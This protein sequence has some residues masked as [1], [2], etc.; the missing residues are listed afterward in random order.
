MKTQQPTLAQT[1][2]KRSA[3]AEV[4][5]NLKKNKGA[6][7]GLAIVALLVFVAVF[8]DVIYDYDTDI[9]EQHIENRLQP[10]SLEHICGTDELGRDIFS[11]LVYGTRFSLSV[12]VLAVIIALIFGVT[13]GAVAGYVGGAVENVI[14]RVTDMFSAIPSILMAIAIVAAMGATTFN[15]MLAIGISSTPA[16]VRVSRAAVLTE[17]NQEYVESARA[18]GMPDWKIVLIHVLPNS[19]SP[20]IVQ[21]TLRVASAIVSASGLS[22]LGLGVPAPAPEWGG[23]LS[24]GRTYIRDYSY[25]SLFPGLAIMITVLSLNLLGDGL[26]DAIDPKLKT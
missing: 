20:I 18:V 7:V 2:K 14:M 21:A 4:W 10:P 11:R 19:I 6:M 12:G 25:M 8:A 9:I 24:V 17:R 26:R 3:L 16:F 23:I 5:R 15:L 13:L 22:F 1:Y